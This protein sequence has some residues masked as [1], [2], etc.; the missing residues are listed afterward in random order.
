MGFNQFSC[1]SYCQTG[2]LLTLPVTAI[3]NGWSSDT[4]G[5]N[6]LCS[7]CNQVWW[8][9]HPDFG[10]YTGNYIFLQGSGGNEPWDIRLSYTFQ[11]VI[12]GN[13]YLVGFWQQLRDDLPLNSWTVT[14]DGTMV[15]NTLPQKFPQYIQTASVVATT[16]SLTI[17]FEGTNTVDDWCS[18]YLNGVTLMQPAPSSQPTYQVYHKHQYPLAYYML[19][20]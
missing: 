3:A 12:P 10:G 18:V 4:G 11:G 5:V 13:S 1:A 9:G 19:Y 7:S 17:V 8:L 20:S 6:L 2:T 15:Y 14:L 16:T